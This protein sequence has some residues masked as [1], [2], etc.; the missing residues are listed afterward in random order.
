M[1]RVV[2]FVWNFCN[3]TQRKAAKERRKWLSEFDLHSL[4]S[5]TSNE[6]GLNAQSIQQVAKQYVRSRKQ[7]RRAWL[8]FRSHKK[9][10]G[11]VPFPNQSIQIRGKL[12]RFHG[13]DY[14]PM[15]WREIPEG[16]RLASGSFTQ[17]SRGR[18]YVNLCFEQDVK[19]QHSHSDTHVGID[20][21]LK[22]L[23]TLNDGTKFAP[24]RHYRLSEKTLGVAQRA[25]KRRRVSTISAHIKNQRKDYLHKISHEITRKYERV[26]VGNVSPSQIIKKPR[27]AKSTLDAGWAIFRAMLS[28]KSIR[29]QFMWCN[30]A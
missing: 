19:V 23:A 13:I 2:N 10:F 14:E 5:N 8:R 17:D 15:H 28:Y 22:D 9:S 30:A 29:E 6:L 11:W 7:H 27:F 24:G 25:R 1:S 18:W 21:G 12:I 4:T 26:Y 3:A 16:A 20:L